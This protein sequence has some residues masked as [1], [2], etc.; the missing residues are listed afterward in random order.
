M[1]FSKGDGHSLQNPA[2]VQSNSSLGNE[3]ILVLFDITIFIGFPN[4]SLVYCGIFCF[5][6]ILHKPVDDKEEH[7]SQNYGQSDNILKIRRVLPT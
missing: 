5:A 7:N 1:K 2:V 3:L 4:H 6:I